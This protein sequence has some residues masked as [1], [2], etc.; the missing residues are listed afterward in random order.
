MKGVAGSTLSL[1]G[2]ENSKMFVLKMDKV[3]QGNGGT[4]GDYLFNHIF[5]QILNYSLQLRMKITSKTLHLELLI[6]E[7]LK[8]GHL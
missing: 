2:E 1:R 3:L 5:A 8:T 6:T 7:I 4:I